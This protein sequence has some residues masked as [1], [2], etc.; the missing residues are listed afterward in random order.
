MFMTN[1]L[2]TIL[3]SFDPGNTDEKKG[4]WRDRQAI[5]VWLKPEHK[6]SWDELKNIYGRKF[7]K[8]IRDV[9]LAAIDHAKSKAS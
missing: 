3:T 9:L 5:T 8:Y 6:A 1:N 7:N 2:E 4:E